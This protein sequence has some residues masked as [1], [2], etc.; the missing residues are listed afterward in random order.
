MNAALPAEAATLA[1]LAARRSSCRAFSAAPVD[2][3]LVRSVLAIAARTPSWSN[4]QPWHVIAASEATTN[5][6][7]TELCN[8]IAAKGERGSDIPATHEFTEPFAARR[9]ETGYGLYGHLGIAR[10]DRPARRA[11][12]LENFRLFGAPRLF[13]ITTPAALGTYGAV[14]CGGFVH[15]LLMALEAH[16]LGA[17]AQGALAEYSAF[18]R[19]FFVI[20][21]DRLVLCGIAFGHPDRAAPINAFRTVRAPLEEIVTFA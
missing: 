6:F 15:A 3:E 7:R 8:H 10:D 19:R 4:T 14:D 12:V 11:Q 1:A 17:I 18:V 21:E 2:P 13:I 5:R 20:P 16:G 9:R